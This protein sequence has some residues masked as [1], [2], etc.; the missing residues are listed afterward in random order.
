MQSLRRFCGR[1]CDCGTGAVW[2]R[3]KN[4]RGVSCEGWWKRNGNACHGQKQAGGAAVEMW[5]LLMFAGPRS[6]N[7]WQACTDNGRRD[8]VPGRG[9]GRLGRPCF[10]NWSIIASRTWRSPSHATVSESALPTYSAQPRESLPRTLIQ[11]SWIK[12][13]PPMSVR[14]SLSTLLSGKVVDPGLGIC[15]G[16]V[17]KHTIYTSYRVWELCMTH[18]SVD[19]TD[20][21]T[22]RTDIA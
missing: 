20:A 11:N 7:E 5:S 21:L 10:P 17:F 2:P 15:R 18:G 14:A 3:A 9:R 1:S 13:W 12:I 6:Q 8:K 4:A 19:Q 16:P 22:G